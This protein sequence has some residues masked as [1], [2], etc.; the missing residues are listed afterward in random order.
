MVPGTVLLIFVILVCYLFFAAGVTGAI[1]LVMGSR[2]RRTGV[3][4]GTLATVMIMGTVHLYVQFLEAC[5]KSLVAE[6]GAISQLILSGA[7]GPTSLFVTIKFPWIMALAL[8]MI[9]C[10]VT[11]G[12]AWMQEEAYCNRLKD[13]RE[14]GEA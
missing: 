1:G 7:D 5:Q 3:I 10:L 2:W 8:W 11:V 6:D 14:S 9:T 13:S 12:V 4:A